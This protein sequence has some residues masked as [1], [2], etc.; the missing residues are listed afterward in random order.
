MVG[1]LAELATPVSAL[2]SATHVRVAE[3]AA[4]LSYEQVTVTVEE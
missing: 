1:W 3:L 2:I 4:V